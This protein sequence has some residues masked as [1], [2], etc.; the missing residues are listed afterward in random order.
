MFPRVILGSRFLVPK[1]SRD[2]LSDKVLQYVYSPGLSGFFSVSDYSVD[3]PFV[4]EEEAIEED[5][6]PYP[7]APAPIP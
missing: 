1:T 5:F 3:G 6:E 4:T 2:G 7:P